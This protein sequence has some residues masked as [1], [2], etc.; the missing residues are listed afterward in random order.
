MQTKILSKVKKKYILQWSSQSPVLNQRD[1]LKEGNSLD[2]QTSIETILT[3]RIMVVC[4]IT[5]ESLKKRD[6]VYSHLDRF[7]S[8]PL[9]SVR[10]LNYKV[11]QFSKYCIIH[12]N[13]E[14]VCELSVVPSK[15]P[16]GEICF[17]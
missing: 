12:I 13:A 8:N 1:H 6:H 14:M 10:R 11:L 17:P 4:P 9:C 7:I 2:F 5:F 3:F 16:A 15:I